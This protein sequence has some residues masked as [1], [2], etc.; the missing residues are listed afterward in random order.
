MVPR[1]VI[2]DLGAFAARAARDQGLQAITL[3]FHGG[4]PLLM[5]RPR[6]AEIS[7]A[8]GVLVDADWIDLFERYRVSVGVSLDGARAANDQHRL[9]QKGRSS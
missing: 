7:Q 5:S 8:N 2:E 3:I 4:E 9:D 6:F 1:Q